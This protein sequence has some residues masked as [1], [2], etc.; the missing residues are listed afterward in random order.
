MQ[1]AAG[2]EAQGQK[3]LMEERGESKKLSG[4]IETDSGRSER[5]PLDHYNSCGAVSDYGWDGSLCFL[6]SHVAV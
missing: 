5:V 1:G 6:T 3:P 4:P 2:G